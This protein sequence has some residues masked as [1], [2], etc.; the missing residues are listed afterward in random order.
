MVRLALVTAGLHN[1]TLL[2]RNPGLCRQLG[3][4]IGPSIRLASRC[5]N[6]LRAGYA[7][8]EWNDVAPFPAWLFSAPNDRVD[9]LVG[10]A[11]ASGIDV[12]GHI[13]ILTDTRSDSGALGPLRDAGAAT[14]SILSIGPPEKEEYLLEGDNQAVRRARSWLQS[15]GLRVHVVSHATRRLFGAVTALTSNVTLALLDAAIRCLRDSGIS[16]AA[17]RDLLSKAVGH[18][19]QASLR[20]GRKLR[21]PAITEQGRQDIAR[22][23]H[24]LRRQNP[25]LAA[26]FERCVQNS[27]DFLAKE[28]AWLDGAAESTRKA[29]G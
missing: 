17:A 22:Q 5:T 13:I 2:A 28:F 29:A 20:A 16:N 14:A 11:L 27:R 15:A 9:G 12:H 6:A 25:A 10:A 24:S 23:I 8:R 3:P 19:I 18:P 7:V 21:R 4:V 26:V 1:G